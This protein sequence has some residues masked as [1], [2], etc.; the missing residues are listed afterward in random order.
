MPE[1][2][3]RLFR[4]SARVALPDLAGPEIVLGHLVGSRRRL[5]AKIDPAR[6]GENEMRRF[7]ARLS[8]QQRRADALVLRL[9]QAKALKRRLDMPPLAP[10]DRRQALCFEIDRQTPFQRN[11]VYYDCAMVGRRESDNQMLVDLWVLPR[12]VIEQAVTPFPGVEVRPALAE[13]VDDAGSVVARLDLR[14]PGARR[15]AGRV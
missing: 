4:R 8:R 7:G 1:A 6:A 11:H 13:I 12:P 3:K 15:P 2:I 9:A 5:L 14:E 10:A